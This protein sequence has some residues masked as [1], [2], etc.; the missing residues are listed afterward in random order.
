MSDIEAQI[1]RL[2]EEQYFQE[3]LLKELDTLIID[4]EGRLEK[5]DKCLNVLQNQLLVI[6]ELLSLKI[7]NVPPPHYLP[8]L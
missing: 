1:Q 5:I 6:Q 4:H 3:K 7:E 8:K 2:Q